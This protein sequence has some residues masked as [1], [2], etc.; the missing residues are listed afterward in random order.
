MSLIHSCFVGTPKV[1]PA[2]IAAVLNRRRRQPHSDR[3]QSREK[4]T[5]TT[6]VIKKKRGRKK[7]KEPPPEEDCSA[8]EDGKEETHSR[9]PQKVFSCD[10]CP[11]QASSN[12]NLKV[13]PWFQLTDVCHV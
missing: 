8:Q 10:Q 12:A 13:S 5:K 6:D 2:L 7:K 1:N 11:Y 4:K 9:Q 3:S